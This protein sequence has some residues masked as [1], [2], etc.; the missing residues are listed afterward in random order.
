MTDYKKWLKEVVKEATRQGWEASRSRKHQK[1]RSPDGRVVTCSL[2]PTNGYQVRFSVTRDL[3]RAGFNV[4][5]IV[6]A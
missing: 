5:P 1:F 6:R 4:D 3:R 2:T